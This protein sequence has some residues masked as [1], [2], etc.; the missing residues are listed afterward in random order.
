MS[1]S[2]PIVECVPNFSEGRDKSKIKTI[3]DA[4]E[5][6]DGVTLLDVEM[7]A[8]TNRS[9]V[10]FI[11]SPQAVEEAAFQAIAKAAQ[12]I[13][14]ATH[15]GEHPRMGATDVCPFVPVEGVTM[16]DCVEIARRVGARVGRDLAIPVYLY[17]EAATK[18]ERRN[19]ADVRRGEYEGLA[20][21]LADPTWKPDFGPTTVNSKSGATV[22]GAREFLIAYNITLNTNDK[23]KAADLAF[24]LREKGRVA[25]AGNTAPYYNRGA[26]LFYGPESFPCGKCDFVAKTFDE[27]RAHCHATHGYDLATLL[28]ANDLDPSNLHGKQVFIPGK[29]AACK[30]I[31]WYV[32]EYKRAQISINLTNYRLTPPHLVLEETR[33]LAAERGL[34]VTGSEIVGLVPWQ[35]LLQAGKFYLEK[36]GSTVG[37]PRRDIL[38]TAVFSMGLNDVA[39]FEIEKKA[40]GLPRTSPKAL[41]TMSVTDFTDEVSRGTPAPGGGSIAAL[42]GSLGAALASMVANL[43]F[44]KEGTESRDAELAR[45]AEQAQSIKDR[46][47]SG[48]DEDTNAFNAFMV[49]LRLPQNTAEEKASRT[50][51]MQEG[52][53]IAIDVPWRTASDSFAALNICGDVAAVGNPNSL[54]DAAVGSQM[55]LAG[56]RGGIWNVVINLKDVKD[57]SYVREMQSKCDKLLAEALVLSNEIIASVD[58]RLA[59]MIEK[60]HN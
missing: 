49:A 11:G 25:R 23:N 40:L 22:I 42:A 36:Q 55:A 10:T 41:V 33:K 54:T 57:T 6:V 20:R 7:G 44:G 3:T 59:E 28:K 53:K 29:F 27:T 1:S 21:K 4:I 15:R 58:R 30:A 12:V 34:V 9:V 45:I 60:R 24:A 32:D 38:D 8:D 51:K 46:L 50:Q 13:D 52:I 5:S 47:Q 31:G 17:E 39:R 14:M 37:V 19:L 18:P 2:T 48:V 26:K 43:T 56:V 35:A 16:K